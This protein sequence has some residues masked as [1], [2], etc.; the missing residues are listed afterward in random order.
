MYSGAAF[1]MAQAMRL[2][3]DYH[4]RHSAREQEIRRRTFW[5][6]L[7]LD[8]LIAF[9]HAKPQTLLIENTDIALPCPEISFYYEEIQNGPR[10]EDMVPFKGLVAPVGL[11]AFFITTV[12]LW[13]SL[14][15]IHV[16]NCRMRDTKPPT[17]P[18]S[19]FSQHARRLKMW[20]SSLPARV[21]WTESN[22]RLHCDLKQGKL[23]AAMHFVLQ[24]ALCVAHQGYLPQT[25]ASSL[26]LDSVD[27]AGRTFE[28]RE[29]ELILTCVSH[30][31]AIGRMTCF[32]FN[33]RDED[34]RNIQSTFVASS[35]LS[36]ASTLLWVHYADNSSQFNQERSDAKE[37][38]D[39][40]LSI[41]RTWKSQWKA[42]A[43]W[44]KS[45]EAIHALYRCAYAAANDGV[46][47]TE[48]NPVLQG[49]TLAHVPFRPRPGDGFPEIGNMNNLYT[50]LRLVMVSPMDTG[51]V[52]NPRYL[53]LTDVLSNDLADYVYPD[54][55]GFTNPLFDMISQ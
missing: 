1:R 44:Y 16:R 36:A 14:A 29:P 11:T 25:D 40:F 31:M 2:N 13:G 20:K 4:Q 45:L 22:Y 10:Y 37:Y 33:G 34:R 49:E 46:D 7:L 23:F 53:H 12:Q 8:R 28:H 19:I 42:A 26:L 39:L 27:A 41:F 9:C 17:D 24:S 50:S 5:S 21:E 3:Q 48:T 38:F 51:V 54:N 15:D 43:A 6:C 32:L 35:L 30:A 47:P 55:A 18:A 52:C